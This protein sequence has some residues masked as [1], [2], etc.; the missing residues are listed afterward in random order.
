MEAIIL[1]GGLGTRLRSVIANIPKAMAPVA[2]RPFLE[3][4]LNMLSQKGFSKVILSLGY[5]AEKISGYFGNHY[6]S[7][8]L[9]YVIEDTALGTGGAIRLAMT[10]CEK[11]HV[12]VFN[13]DT[14]IDLEVESIEQQW[15]I[16]QNLIV[17]CKEMMDT[18]R[19]GLVIADDNIVRKFAEKRVHGPGIINA[20][21]YL[22]NKNTLI[23]FP[24]NQ[25]F[26]FE[27]DFLKYVVESETVEMYLTKSQFIDIGIPEDYK[28]AQLIFS[29]N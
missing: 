3:I 29:N 18:S 11:D 17:V 5:M 1:A 14:Y 24:L 16:N 26:S 4:L 12:F 15:K 6:E 13:G 19:Y 2:G 22:L 7:L 27:N 23:N 25:P 9:E 8:N 20:G 28:R 21:C 10:V